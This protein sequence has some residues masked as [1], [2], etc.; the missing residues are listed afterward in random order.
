MSYSTG[1]AFKLL[2]G[3]MFKFEQKYCSGQLE[4]LKNNLLSSLPKD[5]NDKPILNVVTQLG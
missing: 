5:S 2:A 1:L 4:S 3:D